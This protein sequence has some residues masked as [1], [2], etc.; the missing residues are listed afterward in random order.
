MAVVLISF[1]VYNVTLYCVFLV[2]PHGQL[3]EI[4]YINFNLYFLVFILSLY[5]LKFTVANRI[6]I[7]IFSTQYF[8]YAFLPLFNVF[9]GQDLGFNGNKDGLLGYHFSHL[10]WIFHYVAI[11]AFNF[12][13][14]IFFFFKFVFATRLTRSATFMISAL[15]SIAVCLAVYYNV[16]FFEDL[17]TRA[18]YVP[19]QIQFYKST[20]LINILNLSFLLVIWLYYNRGH[21]VL[22]DYVP[23]ILSLYTLVVILE[24]F[25]LFIF[26]NHNLYINGLYFQALINFGFLLLWAI[27]IIYLRSPEAKENENYVLNYDL[28]QGFIEK[29]RTNNFNMFIMKFGKR[30]LMFISFFLLLL[31][32]VPVWISERQ[33]FFVKFNI[34]ILTI[35]LFVSIIYTLI[36]IQ[37]RWYNIIGFIFKNR[38]N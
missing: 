8:L 22:S 38:L 33:N 2:L 30:N 5:S 20:Y 25:H 27:R 10:Y 4:V 3:N 13:I 1:L 14:T 31:I 7:K 35:S 28:L 17:F 12:L 37:K 15:I 9:I 34:L 11:S 26:I 29:P 23:S 19:V 6:I 24:I 36:Y 18:D 32:A 21:F 16:F